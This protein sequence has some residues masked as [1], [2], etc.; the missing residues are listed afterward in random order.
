MKSLLLRS[1]SACLVSLFIAA[2]FTTQLKAQSP[3]ITSLSPDSIPQGSSDF[4]LTV[5]GTGFSGSTAGSSIR[6][7]GTSLTTSV[8]SDTQATAVVPASFLTAAGSVTINFYKAYYTAY[9]ISNSVTFLILAPLR[10]LTPPFSMAGEPG[11]VLTLDGDFSAMAYPVVQWNGSNR[12]TTVLN[13][14]QLTANITTEDLASAGTAA[15][16]VYSG[17]PY[18][19]GTILATN[20]LDFI[21]DPP[22]SLTSISPPSAAAGSPGFT[23]T[24]DGYGFRPEYGSQ[25]LWNGQ[26]RPSTILSTTRITAS[27]PSTDIASRGTAGVSISNISMKRTS[28]SRTFSITTPTPVLTSLV[29]SSI[30]AGS[31]GLTLTVIGANFVSPMVGTV[32][33]SAPGSVIR[34]NGTDRTTSFIDSTRLTTMVGSHEI[35]AAGVIRVSVSNEAQGGG[36]SNA[37]NWNIS[38]PQPTIT[39]ISPVRVLVG[40][41]AQSVTVSGSGFVADSSVRFQGSSRPTTFVSTS[42]LSVL[43]S[44]SDLSVIGSYPLTVYNSTP[45]GGTSNSVSF[46]VFAPTPVISSLT[47]PSVVAG[48]TG[49]VLTVH[50]SNFLAPATG[51]RYTAGSMILW[52]GVSRPTSYISDSQLNTTVTAAEIG[53]AELIPI[54]VSNESLGGGVSNALTFAVNNPTPRITTIS[55]VTVTLGSSTISLS[56]TGSGFV[57]GSRVQFQGSDRPTAFVSSAEL[58]ATL[59]ASDFQVAVSAAITV[60][61]PSPGGGTSNSVTFSVNAPTAVMESISPQSILAGSGGF[62]LT[63]SGSNFLQP[64]FAGS[65]AAGSVILWNGVSR[66]TRFIDP[67]HLTAAIPESDVASAGTASVSVSNESLG[68]GVSK[69][70]LFTVNNPLPVLVAISPPRVIPGIGPLSLSISGKGFVPESVVRFQGSN[71]PTTYVSSTQLKAN[72]PASDFVDVG[73]AII[74]VFNSAPGGG[75]SNSLTLSIGAQTPGIE[76]LTP[77]SLPAGSGDFTLT[78]SGIHFAAP[79]VDNTVI[80]GS[81]IRWNGASRITSYVD[82]N[83]LTASI[84]AADVAKAGTVTITVSN[85][86]QGGGVSNGATF[87]INNPLPTMI[88]MNPK[89]LSPGSTDTTLTVDGSGFVG[90]SVIR[91]M[92]KD[93]PTTFVSST[94]LQAKL[95]SSDFAEPGSFSIAVFNPAPGGGTSNALPLEV[96]LPVPEI[97]SLSP[98]S[99]IAG[100]SGFTLTVIGSHFV[101]PGTGANAYSGTIVLWNGSRRPTTFLDS[102]RLTAA[103]PA[104]DISAAGTVSVGVQTEAPGGAGSNIVPFT[105][106]NPAPALSSILPRQVLLRSGSVSLTLSGSG[107]VAGSVVRFQGNNRTTTYLSSTQLRATL[108]ASDLFLAGD[109]PV[110]V[111]NPAPGGGTSSPLSFTVLPA[112]PAFSLTGLPGTINPASQVPVGLALGT[113]YPIDLSGML[114]LSFT[115]DAVNP[116]DDPAILFVTGG[117][118]ASFTIPAGR[119]QAV[120]GASSST[121]TFQTGTVAGS[122][123]LGVRLVMSGAD[124]PIAPSPNRSLVMARSAPKIISLAIANRT[125]AGFDL[126]V[127][128]YATTRSVGM[129]TVSFAASSSG[130]LSNTVFTRDISRLM[131]TWYQSSESAAFGSQFKLTFPFTVSGNLAAVG[132]V[133]LVL[134]NENGASEEVR[135]NF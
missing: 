107:F 40:S 119:T 1:R 94:Q 15:V 129:A 10:T 70:A 20:T 78:V 86:T 80:P 38:N 68:G 114:T 47:P 115:A 27:I 118:T 31:A 105:V 21:I 104:A 67:K 63:V 134:S 133:G 50:G 110:T 74:T 112:L 83:H 126:Q 23:I 13:T 76:S 95:P 106:Y 117:R 62:T 59:P 46:S 85:Q 90:E 14:G 121:A 89:R 120:F 19:R 32:A 57:S 109:F 36:V 64:G 99:A 60:F 66:P 58:Q 11:F 3:T 25:L 98:S 22:L 7:N 5:N 43:L 56:V 75:L 16:R 45:G 92:G 113:S 44:D 135:V 81:I 87:T 48:S 88:D 42:Q 91:Y 28:N 79:I 37:L 49:F 116:T 69:S 29:P 108:P 2:I 84:P 52:K 132:S 65:S 73:P 127:T 53:S 26:A 103:I 102:S 9:L 51:N 100:S 61:S 24:A 12:T 55:P 34:F 35:E 41:K 18:P 17:M 77:S 97:Q 124:V 128:G 122:I 4:T 125:A 101:A 6:W 131:T 72:L 33:A 96:A 111:F 82:A 130:S 39:G 30:L 8:L 93:R 54:T 123:L 71:R